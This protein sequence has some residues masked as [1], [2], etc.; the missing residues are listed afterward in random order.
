MN[1]ISDFMTRQLWTVQLDDSIA[2]ARRMIAE[3]EIHHLPVINRGAVVGMVTERDLALAADRLGTV[4]DVVTA[5][6]CVEPDA[7][8][9]EVL[10]TMTERHLDSVVVTTDGAVEGIFTSSDAVRA[11]RDALK[12]PAQNRRHAAH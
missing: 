3:R 2:V 6:E 4:A 1:R 7:G 8:L 9:D 10:D 11:L 12:S 5:V